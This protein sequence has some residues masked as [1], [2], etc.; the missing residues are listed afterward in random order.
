MR[1]TEKEAAALG[2]T[3]NF[4]PEDNEQTK[5]FMDVLK[6]KR[7]KYNAVKTKVDGI[8]FDSKREAEYYSELKLRQKAG[9]ILGFCRQPQFVLDDAGTTYRADFI[10]FYP[11]GKAEVI[12]VK[13]VET[14]VFKLKMKM[15]KMRYPGL[16]VRT[17]SV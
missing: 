4:T 17:V 14:Q 1:I 8:T 3:T 12:D 11:D 15:F 9:E 2:I 6:T 10:V 16:E 13:G 5:Y 7:N